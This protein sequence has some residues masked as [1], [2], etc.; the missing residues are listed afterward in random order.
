MGT[1]YYWR[2]NPCGS[3]KRYEEIH[4]GKKS[5]GWTFGFRAYQ[6][7]LLDSEHPE[8]GYDPASPFA[9]EVMSRADWREI[10]SERPGELRDEYGRQVDDPIAWID[11]LEP[12]DANAI[13]WE[14]AQRGTWPS[15]AFVAAYGDKEH[16][17]PE[18]F[19]FGAYEFS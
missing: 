8:W 17:D 5:A 2:D 4:V 16:R 14:D 3:C 1:N 11:G 19:H 10:F 6:H 7:R 12:P 9:S 15:E 13:A 18:G